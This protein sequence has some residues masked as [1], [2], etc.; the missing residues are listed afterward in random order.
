MTK[1]K[2]L[3]IHPTIAPYRVDFFNRLYELFDTKICLKYINLK[4]QKFDYKLISDRFLFTPDYLPEGAKYRLF[5]SLWHQIKDSNSDIVMT[6]EFGLVTLTAL[7]VRL[8]CHKSYKIVVMTDDS[9]DMVSGGKDFSFKHRL[10]RFVLASKIDDLIVVEPRVEC[11]YQ[12][13]YGKGF[14]FPIIVDEVKAAA[15]YKSLQP[16]SLQIAEKY[17]LIGKKVLLSVSR[18][19]ELKNL[20]RV[21]DAFSQTPTDATLVIVGDGDERMSLEQHAEKVD[22]EIIF[23]GRFDGDELYAWYNIASVFILASYQESFGAVTNEALL[24]G[25][26]VIISEKAGSSCLVNDDNGELIN[27]FDTAAMSIAIKR[28]LDTAN[29]PD[30]STNRNSLMNLSFEDRMSKLANRFI[31]Y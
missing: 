28:Q 21:I 7:I 1:K 19:V 11:W 31:N 16:L 5:K 2:L 27:P 23:T 15:Y 3:I 25:C 20:H 30:L 12:D 14:Y 22:K 13:K 10:A 6:C 24:S 26:R 17:N 29:I 9:F 4:S 8:I 18:L